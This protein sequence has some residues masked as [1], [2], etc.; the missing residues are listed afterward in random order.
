ML[1]P[2][3]LLLALVTGCG[4]TSYKIPA[5]EL[6]RLATLPPEQ[7]GQNVRVVQQLSDAD[8]GAPQPVNG[9]TQIVIFPSIIIDNGGHRRGW[10]PHAAPPAARASGGGG[11]G[12]H[13]AN[14]GASDGKAE[15]IALVVLAVTGLG[16]AAVVEGSRDDGYA[17]VHPMAPLYLTCLDGSH[18]VMPLAA[19]DPDSAAFSEYAIIR[20]N[21]TPW[22]W[23]GRAPLDRVG[24]T[25]A[26]LAGTG[27]FQSADGSKTAGTATTIQLGFFPDQH[28]GIVGS[29]FLGWRDNSQLQTLFETRYTLE[30]EGYLAQAGPL[31]FGLYGGGGG[32]RR[33]EDGVAG[34]NASGLALLGGAQIQLDINTRLA[35]TARFGQ[36][37]A[38]DERMT[39]AL[40][41]LAVY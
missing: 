27:T 37:Y 5:S 40:F 18:V 32:A 16:I 17:Q 34:G 10:G 15:A 28:V 36:T 38:H 12:L 26:V 31:H 20:S 6:Q 13:V 22:H 8:V 30:V 19:L 41:G 1:K 35:L 7:R 2:T 4:T 25:Y 33:L 39:D 21:E 11:G 23:N 14:S 3:A 29:M 24:L 9:E